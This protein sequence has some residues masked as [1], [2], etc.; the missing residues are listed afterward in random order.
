VSPPFRGTDETLDREI[1]TLEGMT[2]VRLRRVAREMRDLDRDLRE[3]K[4]ERARR[5]AESEV[6]ASNEV[7]ATEGTTP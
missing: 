3:L 2:R 5:R 6:K 4:R 7:A 1:E